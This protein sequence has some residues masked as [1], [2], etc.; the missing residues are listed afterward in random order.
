MACFSWSHCSVTLRVNE[1]TCAF[2]MVPFAADMV[3][4]LNG[5]VNPVALWWPSFTSALFNWPRDWWHSA[6]GDSR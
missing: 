2:L 6:A 1:P 5:F 4:V 3:P